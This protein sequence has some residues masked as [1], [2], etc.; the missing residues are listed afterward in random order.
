MS[1]N[2]RRIVLKASGEILSG[3]RGFGF[4]PPVLDSIATDVAETHD[5]GVQI[6]LVIGGGNIFRGMTGT[7]RGVERVTGDNMGM[8]AT[9]INALALQDRL[10]HLGKPTRVM[11][12][13]EMPQVCERFIRRRAERHLEKGRIVISAAGTGNP[14][15][16][17]DTAAALRAVE[18]GAD[19][20]L[21]GTKVDG[22]Y[23]ADPIK[24]PT[25]TRFDR[26]SFRRVLDDGLQ[27]MD[28]TAVAL[29]M[30]N[31]LPIVVFKITEQGSFARVVTGRAPC[32]YVGEDGTEARARQK[33]GG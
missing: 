25:A 14:Y 33:T 13:L 15:F 2:Y 9:V 22:V 4:D 32:T 21:K 26:L 23:T 20:L 12:A 24:D 3:T 1:A 11:S 29:C 28:S 18:L 19:I 10:E 6:V 17:T 8:I 5:L 7:T 16:T 31:K 27:V 30:E